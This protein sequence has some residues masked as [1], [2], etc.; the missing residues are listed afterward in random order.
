MPITFGSTIGIQA[1]S[2]KGERPELPLNEICLRAVNKYINNYDEARSL[3]ESIEKDGLIEPITVNE[4]SA[5]LK[6]KDID[7]LPKDEKE[8]YES[9]LNQGFKYFVTTG[10]RRFRAYCSLALGK[11]VHTDEEVES[12]Y[13]AFSEVLENSRKAE[14]EGR[15]ADINKY[16]SIKCF[17]AKD[18]VAQENARY[19]RSNLDQ[20]RIQDFEIVD[21]IIDE[22][23][24]NGKLYALL[25]ENKIAKIKSMSDRAV[26]DTFNRIAPEKTYATIDEARNTLLELD[27]SLFPGYQSTCNQV[28]SDY[29]SET[30]SKKISASSIKQARRVLTTLNRDYIK[31]IYEGYLPYKTSIDLLTI[32]DKI[33][34]D[35]IYKKI[36]DGTFD[37]KKEKDKYIEKQPKIVSISN[38]EL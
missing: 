28:I 30:K 3:K 10:H 24:S 20:R 23:T 7:D 29:I 6:S 14:Q 16:C 21:N 18:N 8:Y 11:D 38:S 5:F 4:I 27:A 2:G 36:K 34:K 1:M 13:T 37:I 17:I 32:Y 33:D 22:M 19:N 9:R 31:L 12:F 26:K 25:E 15:F 35:E